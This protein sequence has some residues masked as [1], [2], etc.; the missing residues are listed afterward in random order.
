MYMHRM[1]NHDT[2]FTTHKRLRH[3]NDNENT[4]VRIIY[5]ISI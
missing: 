4:R 5:N 1:T 2:H 3:K